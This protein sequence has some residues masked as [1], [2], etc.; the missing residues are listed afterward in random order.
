MALAVAWDM[1]EEG[2]LQD[3]G[4]RFFIDMASKP[5]PSDDQSF[6]SSA[7][8]RRVWDC[9]IEGQTIAVCKWYLSTW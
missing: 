6:P 3:T 8:A 9:E 1:A 2:D 4:K 7:V 5:P